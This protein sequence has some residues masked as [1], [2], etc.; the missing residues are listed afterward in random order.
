MRAFFTKYA[1]AIKI[2]ALVVAA[3]AVVGGVSAYAAIR[4]NGQGDETI[5]ER[6][7]PYAQSETVLMDELTTEE[8]TTEVPVAEEPATQEDS[9]IEFDQDKV[10]QEVSE[11]AENVATPDDEK[12]ANNDEKREEDDAQNAGK[13]PGN[14]EPDGPPVI[15][16]P[17]QPTVSESMPDSDEVTEPEPDP[18]PE[19][20]DPVL[21]ESPV[22][23]QLYRTLSHSGFSKNSQDKWSSMDQYYNDG[24]PVDS[25]KGI[26]VSYAQGEIDFNAVKAAGIDF[27]II[28]VGARGYETGSLI[29]DDWFATN[30]ENASKAGLDIGVYFY[31]QA[32]TEEE[33]IEEAKM[34]LD[35]IGRHPSCEI[36]YPVVIDVEGV[37]G[38]ARIDKISDVQLN[39]NVTAFCEVIRQAGYYPMI[40]A[41]QNYAENRLDFSQLPYDYWMAAY[42]SYNT[43][44]GVEIPFV[45]WQY[46]STGSVSGVSGDVDRNV[47]LVDYATYLRKN[48]WNKLK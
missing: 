9:L 28:R 34:V 19:P 40:Y 42:R 37:N 6:P 3:V 23:Y 32:V 47:S 25:W 39:K 48:G 5:T 2:S 16:E 12:T 38:Q 20:A 44:F 43:T 46:T 30:I 7:V 29:L 27:V 17:E 11:K 31:S 8:L 36:T 18:D 21:P 14:V 35:H 4:A 45:L 22:K 26:D 13:N 41:D 24:Q 10:A 33:A 15:V 1:L